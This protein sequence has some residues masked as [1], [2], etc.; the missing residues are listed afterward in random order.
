MG[1]NSAK[2]TAT[3]T[4]LAGWLATSP[5]N[6]QRLA[7]KGTV[8]KVAWGRYDLEKSVRSVIRELRAKAGIDEENPTVSTKAQ[9]A[10]KLLDARTKLLEQRVKKEVA[11]VI[12]VDDVNE[13]WGAIVPGLRAFARSLPQKIAAAVPHLNAHDRAVVERIVED[14]LEDCGLERGFL[15]ARARDR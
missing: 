12:D 1:S 14:G 11:E 15:P 10:A 2:K 3:A 4:E 7:R 6:I 13:T 9:A 8:A 5:R